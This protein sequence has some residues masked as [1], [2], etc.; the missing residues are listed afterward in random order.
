MGFFD[1]L[2]S[3]ANNA[4]KTNYKNATGHSYDNDFKYY[5]REW[6]WKH[7][8]ELKDRWAE[9]ENDNGIR[10]AAEKAAVR[11]LMKEKGFDIY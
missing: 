4:V 7:D 5:L 9:L 3:A 11:E 1:S 8:Y 2:V 6:E 10:H